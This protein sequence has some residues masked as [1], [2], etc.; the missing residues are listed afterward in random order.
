[1]EHTHQ[2]EGHL[3]SDNSVEETELGEDYFYAL[4]V[5]K[6]NNVSNDNKVESVIGCV[7]VSTAS[8]LDG[9][10]SCI[11]VV[12]APKDDI[13][14]LFFYNSNATKNCILQLAPSTVTYSITSAATISGN[15][16]INYAINSNVAVGDLVTGSG[17]PAFTIVVAVNSTTQCVLSQ[18]ATSTASGLTFS[19]SR[20]SDTISL[21]LQYSLL[22]FSNLKI[23]RITGYALGNLLYFTD[24]LNEP[25]TVHLTRYS[26]G[27]TPNNIEEIYMLKRGPRYAPYTD[28]VI[29]KTLYGYGKGQDGTGLNNNNIYQDTQF[30]VQYQYVDGQLSVLSPYSVMIRK[31]REDEV[32]NYIR[33]RVTQDIDSSSASTCTIISGNALITC[34]ST[35]GLY[36][37]VYVSDNANNTIIP[38]LSRITTINSGTTFTITNNALSSTTV[39]LNFKNQPDTI[40]YLVT[41]INLFSRI[42]QSGTFV[43]I[44]QITRTLGSSFSSV[45][46]YIDYKGVTMGTVMESH[47]LQPFENLPQQVGTMCAAGSRSWIGNYTEGYAKYD[48][49]NISGFGTSLFHYYT[50][51]NPNVVNAKPGFTSF[52]Y[53]S[54]YKI[55]F[56]LRDVNLRVMGVVT[57]PNFYLDTGTPDYVS[58]GSVD[59]PSTVATLA[60][61]LTNLPAWCYDVGVV[62]TKDTNKSFFIQDYA[63]SPGYWVAL[64]SAIINGVSSSIQ[65]FSL[66]YPTGG[67]VTL[68][69]TGVTTTTMVP[70]T[71]TNV[72][73]YSST[74]SG[75]NAIFTVFISNANTISV[76]VTTPGKNYAI[77]DTI[78]FNSALTA[79]MGTGTSTWTIRNITNGAKYYARDI[80]AIMSRGIGYTWQA[81]DRALLGSPVAGGGQQ[82]LLIESFDGT[83]IYCSASPLI[84]A[85]LSNDLSGSGSSPI[86]IYRPIQDTSAVSN[87]FYELQPES[88]YS[89]NVLNPAGPYYI[90]AAGAAINSYQYGS[91]FLNNAGTA[92]VNSIIDGDCV[93]A[94]AGFIPSGISLVVV[95]SEAAR[96][97]P[98]W[99]TSSGRPFVQTRLDL[100]QKNTWTRYGGTYVSGTSINQLAEFSGLSEQNISPNAGTLQKLQPTV[101]D[102]SQSSAILA[103]CNT[104]TYSIYI[105][106]ALITTGNAS[107]IVAA[108]VNIIG[109]IRQQQSG[110]GT[111]HPESVVMD[112]YG[113]VYWFDTLQRSYV[114]YSNNGIVA[115]SMKKASTYFYLQAQANTG[116]ELVFS[117]Y[118]PYYEMILVCFTNVSGAGWINGDPTKATIGYSIFDERWDGFYSTS[119]N[120][121]FGGGFFAGSKNMYSFFPN[122]SYIWKHTQF[123]PYAFIQ[124][125]QQK[126]YVSLSLVPKDKTNLHDWKVLK[127]QGHQAFFGW[128]AGVES[129][130]DTGFSAVLTNKNGQK[131][132]LLN[133][134]PSGEQEFEVEEN[135]I[136]AVIKYDENSINKVTGLVDSSSCVNGDPMTSNTIQVA[137][138][139]TGGVYK[140]I[141]TVAVGYELSRGHNV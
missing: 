5:V 19:G 75:T 42:G 106:E 81:G 118:D 100:A 85:G 92:S 82:D 140:Y 15:T 55:G 14:Y 66:S 79:F 44:G 20:T 125:T 80:S 58:G 50:S 93:L 122:G 90:A 45:S 95:N 70:G 21:V 12:T 3:N 135:V 52:T 7:A 87:L 62:I 34:V 115:I 31:Q 89:F 91:Y 22:A 4:N 98:N 102:S 71:Y 112:S 132:T 120:P 110:Y 83:Y 105:N 109:D 53:Y 108:S 137:I 47:Y 9:N 121:A 25:K 30:A 37:G 123:A 101:R 61:T 86:M 40:P 10:S 41:Q 84:I 139:W 38:Y 49:S 65:T 103:I 23:N 138:V 127:I 77:G 18:A 74:G 114:R 33:V 32:Y 16:T 97:N 39:S 8:Y 107:G 67:I 46:N 51:T 99:N 63:K 117:A 57:D 43:Q 1:M 56:V 11:G 78:T 130:I 128:S 35:F 141:R 27:S 111:L 6:D 129:V 76:T 72:T 116:S 13:A 17:I 133:N 68:E 64:N 28:Y 2:F 54:K 24:N 126:C 48:S 94:L 119:F 104:D 124:G 69:K 131:A 36:P 73:A 113:G 29:G 136:Y 88:W 96:G 134:R 59:S 26:G 60:A